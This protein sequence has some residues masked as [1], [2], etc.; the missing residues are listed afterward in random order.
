MQIK[1]FHHKKAHNIDTIWLIYKFFNYKPEL[2]ELYVSS[3]PK[4]DLYLLH[5]A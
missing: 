4:V 5:S 3:V 1:H 2:L